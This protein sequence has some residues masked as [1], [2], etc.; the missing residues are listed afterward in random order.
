MCFLEY[1]GLA[2]K[3]TA[4]LS[5]KIGR[6]AGFSALGIE[7]RWLLG[8]TYEEVKNCILHYK[9][10]NLVIKDLCCEI[11]GRERSIQVFSKSSQTVRI[12]GGFEICRACNT[13]ENSLQD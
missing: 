8:S 9:D 1:D 4:D 3:R 6:Y 7:N 13:N 5:I 2:E 11:C 12:D 10:P